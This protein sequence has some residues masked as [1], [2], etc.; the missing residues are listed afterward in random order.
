[1]R[2]VTRIA[3]QAA[4]LAIAAP[5]FAAEPEPIRLGVDA[6]ADCVDEASLARDI[7]AL[8]STFRRANDEER[9]R[10]F[11]VEV[12]KE[13]RVT[14]RLVVR[15]LVGEETTRCIEA[16]TCEQ[17]SRALAVFVSLALDERP[18]PPEPPAQREWP[19]PAVV[20]DDREPKP[21]PR[22]IS[23]GA[24][25]ATGIYGGNGRVASVGG[26]HALAA[27]RV[28]Q[29]TRLGIAATFTHE[30][31]DVG[32]GGDLVDAE[33]FVGRAGTLIGWGAPW[34]NRAWGFVAELGIMHGVLDETK[35]GI[36]SPTRWQFTSP[37]V[38]SSIVVQIAWRYAVRPVWMFGGLFEPIHPSGKPEIILTG[39]VGLVWQAW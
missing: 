15:D 19:L 8:G 5:A 7:E 34:N 12:K 16:A 2:A 11:A 20:V 1:M 29:T 22:P 38:S 25:V 37:Y 6:P 28:T 9:A 26:V 23:N 18:A 3:I 39:E 30:D 27:S 31:H 13:T 17:V 33:G 14:G 35:A 21:P 24:I 36:K 4:A 32:R 10:S